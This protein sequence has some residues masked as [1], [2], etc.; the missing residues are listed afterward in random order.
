VGRAPGVI[1]LPV[2][3]AGAGVSGGL[4]ES[5]E[6][7]GTNVAFNVATGHKDL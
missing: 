7:I 2:K 6:Q 4:T 3:V 5:G 1:G